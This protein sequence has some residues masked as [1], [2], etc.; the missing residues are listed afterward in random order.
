MSPWAEET[1]PENVIP[2]VKPPTESDTAPNP[3]TGSAA[4]SGPVPRQRFQSSRGLELP[5]TAA[6]PAEVL[7]QQALKSNPQA[8]AAKKKD[9]QATLPPI[10]DGPGPGEITDGATPPPQPRRT[11]LYIAL[12]LAIVALLSGLIWLVSQQQAS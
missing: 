9:S 1:K 8:P 10:V 5:T 11:G 6:D 4:N 3:I 12:L 7:R 2:K